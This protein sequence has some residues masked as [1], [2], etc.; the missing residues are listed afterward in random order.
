ML[1]PISDAMSSEA[2]NPTSLPSPSSGNILMLLNVLYTPGFVLHTPNLPLLNGRTMHALYAISFIIY[3]ITDLCDW[4]FVYFTLRGYVTSFPLKTW[5]AVGLVST[6]VF[7][8]ML[9][10]LLL[11]LCVENAFAHRLDIAPYRSGFAIIYEAFVQ[12]VQAFN[13][14]RI[15]FLFMILHDMPI[16]IMNFVFITSCRCVGPQILQWPLIISSSATT[17]SV[18]WRLVMLYFAYRRMIFPLKPVSRANTI[19]RQPTVYEQFKL[20]L[21]Q[22][23]G[24]R[25]NDYDELWPVR[26]SVRKIYGYEKQTI[27]VKTD[28]PYQNALF[29]LRFLLIPVLKVI[30]TFLLTLIIYILSLLTCCAPCC[31]HYICSSRSFYHRHKCSSSFVRIFSQGFHWTLFIT[32]LLL[33]VILFVLN[34]ILLSSVHG[35]GNNQITFEISHVCVAISSSQKTIQTSIETN[36]KEHLSTSEL[37][38][39]CK[40]IWE[41]GAFRIGL[42]RQEAGIWQTRITLTGKQILAISTKVR[43]DYES[44]LQNPSHTLYYDYVL[45]QHKDAS[46]QSYACIPG[47]KTD[48][49][50]LNEINELVWPYYA[51]CDRTWTIK[52]DTLIDCNLYNRKNYLKN[53]RSYLDYVFL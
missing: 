8:S 36:H 41:D 51:A 16:T 31:Y 19:T 18:L 23:N 5:L 29:K 10:S 34:A 21:S 27:P 40:P 42:N 17:I 32:S 3:S 47:N 15:A 45:L 6:T 38:Y 50:F 4:L 2:I 14:F 46:P 35:L 1:L 22:K 33:T 53:K 12:W 39:T 9:T 25:L 20:N 28:K 49:R 43:M 37:R 26:Y 44:D 11:V 7:G 24:G 30:L 13:N 48:W 52:W